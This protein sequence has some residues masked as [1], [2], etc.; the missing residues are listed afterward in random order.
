MIFTWFLGE[1]TSMA[2]SLDN[3]FLI[4]GTSKGNVGVYSLD[5]ETQFQILNGPSKNYFS[6]EENSFN[7]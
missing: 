7:I 4:C 3:N 2:V 6:L 1:I 5:D